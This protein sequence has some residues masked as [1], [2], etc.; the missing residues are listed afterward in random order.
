MKIYVI[1]HTFKDEWEVLIVDEGKKLEKDQS[2]GRSAWKASILV[3]SGS[4][5]AVSVFTIFSF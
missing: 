2:K 5:A 3:P 1:S 4:K